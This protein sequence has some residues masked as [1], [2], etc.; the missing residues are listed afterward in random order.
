MSQIE[1]VQVLLVLILGLALKLREANLAASGAPRDP[2][3]ELFW[4]V[5]LIALNLTT[6]VLGFFLTLQGLP[7][8]ADWDTARESVYIYC[9]APARWL[10]RCCCKK[11]CWAEFETCDAVTI[12]AW[13]ALGGHATRG[14]NAVGRKHR[15]LRR[16]LHAATD[17]TARRKRRLKRSTAASATIVP[18]SIAVK[19]EVEMVAETRTLEELRLATGKAEVSFEG[20]LAVQQHRIMR[21]EEAR[22]SERDVLARA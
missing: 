2:T 1:A 12:E 18:I 9:C 3:A 15:A 22:R 19:S 21:G 10:S 4:T 13:N 11:S 16:K 6:V 5:L 20:A 7:C 8:L 14:R 17:P